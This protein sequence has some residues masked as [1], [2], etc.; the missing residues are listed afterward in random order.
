MEELRSVNEGRLIGEGEAEGMVSSP[1]ITRSRRGN[2]T[3]I[4][5]L[6]CVHCLLLRVGNEVVVEESTS[7]VIN[8]RPGGVGS[9]LPTG[10]PLP[11]LDCQSWTDNQIS[12]QVTFTSASNLCG[13]MSILDL[14]CLLNNS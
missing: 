10:C 1:S 4:V 9:P 3:C 6:F 7:A 12:G 13:G 8:D 2:A 14:T 11:K 5:R